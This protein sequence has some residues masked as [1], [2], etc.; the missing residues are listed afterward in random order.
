MSEL[1]PVMPPTIVGFHSVELAVE[2]VRHAEASIARVLGIKSDL[3]H[4]F[5]LDNVRLALC[6]WP[7]AREAVQAFS[8]VSHASEEHRESVRYRI[9]SC[10][11]GSL[12]AVS[13]SDLE[14][15]PVEARSTRESSSTAGWERD[16][17]VIFGLDHLVIRSRDVDET[18]AFYRDQLGLRVLFDREF[19]Q[20]KVRLCMLRVGDAV[21]EI[22]GSLGDDAATTATE[23]GDRDRLWGLTWRVGD[24]DSAHSRLQEQGIDVS[25]PRAGRRP[26]TRVLTVRESTC[27]VPTLLIQPV[28]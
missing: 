11:S 13:L 14:I 21:L 10:V 23:A 6:L 20:W 26:G 18:V 24:L 27:G 16:P 1:P 2:D 5:Q 12:S 17:A 15:A 8:M 25:R 22:A 3:D 4:S 19:P 7:S 9:G 28:L